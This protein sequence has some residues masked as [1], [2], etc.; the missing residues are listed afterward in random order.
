MIQNCWTKFISHERMKKMYKWC[1]MSV[2]KIR[3]M[4]YLVKNVI[5]QEKIC[6][7][8][9]PDSLKLKDIWKNNV[10]TLYCI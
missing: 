5:K 7:T 2:S 8:K 6:V 3:F 4:R 10:E 1:G 9:L